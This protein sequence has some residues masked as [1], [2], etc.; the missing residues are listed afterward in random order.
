M[1]RGQV[2]IRNGVIAALDIGTTKTL[3]VIARMV[4]GVPRVAGIGLHGTKG[5]KAGVITDLDAAESA[6]L[7]AVHQAESQAGETLRGVFVNLSGGNPSSRTTAHEIACAGHEI[8]DADLQR[9]SALARQSAEPPDRT[10][11]HSIPVSYSIDRSRGIRDPRGMFGE[12]LAVRMHVVSASTGAL[13]TLASCLA[14][15]HLELDG[16]VVSPYAAGLSS[17]VGDERELGVTL[18]DM[19]GGTTT[20]AVF[21]DNHVVYA[22][23]V[24]IGGLHVTNDLA[25]GLSTPLAHAERLKTLYGA[26]IVASADEREMVDVPLVGE[27]DQ[28]QANPVPRSILTGIIQPRLEETFELVRSRL[29][30]SGFDGV[31]GGR[32][33]LT[34]GGSQLSGVRDLASLILDKQVRVGRPITLPGLP[35]NMAG[36]AFATAAGLIAHALQPVVQP[37]RSSRASQPAPSSPI[38]RIGLWLK[39]NF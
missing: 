37:A 3:C 22:D 19:G 28:V 16:V 31:A 1:R 11:L 32:V 2:R 23:S 18:I 38:G 29:E 14:R 7:S 17:L 25:R 24:P 9:L 33:V 13:R 10:A 26:A 36:P 34:G 27:E 8:A 20:M 35:Q 5:V 6:V 30:A 39:E 21:C 4:D 12:R 15:C